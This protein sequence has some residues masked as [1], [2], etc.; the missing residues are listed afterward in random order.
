MAKIN[1]MNPRGVA[2]QLPNGTPVA[3]F[4]IYTDAVSYVERLIRG[5]F[6]ATAIA[7]VGS[8]LSTVERVKAKISYGKIALNGAMTGLWLG[9]FMFL[10][11][12][13]TDNAGTSTPV[14]TLS[15][16]LLVGAGFGML[17]QVI[18]FSLSKGKRGFSSGSLVV[19]KKYE[20][21]IPSELTPSVPEALVKGGEEA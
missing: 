11:F 1:P 10:I 9:L 3:E 2:S 21:V 8:D 18:R 4:N 15:T 19:A 7:I 5:D 14:F 12:G 17:W 13:T 16:A 20:V 6:P